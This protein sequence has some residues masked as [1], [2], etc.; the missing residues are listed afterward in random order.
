MADL[1]QELLA[2]RQRIDQAK[3]ESQRLEGQV[4]QLERQRLEEFGCSTD[5]EA[6]EY[7]RDLE[8]HVAQLESDIQEGIQAMREELG[9]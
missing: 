1:A 6:D 9:W 7:V 3:A 5:E 8:T 2:M 4:A